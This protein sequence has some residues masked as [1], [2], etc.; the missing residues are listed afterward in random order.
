MNQNTFLYIIKFE[1]FENIRNKWILFYSVIFFILN[2]LIIYFGSNEGSRIIPSILNVTLLIVPLFSLIFGG[3]S[4]TESLPFMEVILSRDISRTKLFTGKWLGSI[5]SLCTGYLLGM[6][7]SYF[8]FFHVTSSS[9]F[10]LI[11][12][13]SYGILLN[14]LFITISFLISVVFTRKEVVLSVSLGLWFYF[15]LLYDLIIMS[16]TVIY[17]DY[18]LEV[19]VLGL[20]VLNPVDLVRIAVLLQMDVAILLGFTAAFFQKYL[21]SIG[22][23]ALTI[24][25]LIF[26]IFLSYFIALRLFIK[27]N[28]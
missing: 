21:G 27:R 10:V 24:F 3:L 5:L 8:T 12:L 19:P 28:F 16:I 20:V 18:P 2:S 14:I 1:F 4:F 15:Y 9:I 26:W 25:F 17:G 6:L 11:Q 22:G 7:I 23:I 13:L